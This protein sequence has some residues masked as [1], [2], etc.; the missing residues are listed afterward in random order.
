[1]ARANEFVVAGVPVIGTAQVRTLRSEGRHGSLLRLH[2]SSAALLAEHTP[3]ID[4]DSPDKQLHWSVG[5][6]LRNIAGVD[7]V[8]TPSQFRRCKQIQH[9]APTK[10]SC[11]DAPY[12]VND[13]DVE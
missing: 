5:R 9:P 7:P 8:L 11:D 1:M 2:H 13:S 12:Q 3:A 6:K 10:H 4:S